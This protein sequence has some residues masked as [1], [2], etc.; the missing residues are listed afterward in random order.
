MA[1]IIHPVGKILQPAGDGSGKQIEQRNHHQ[2]AR[3]TDRDARADNGAAVAVDVIQ[4]NQ[5]AERPAVDAN[6]RAADIGKR[7][8]I[9]FALIRNVIFCFLL[10]RPGGGNRQKLAVCRNVGKNR[11]S[12]V[13]DQ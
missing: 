2:K 12:A 10:L 6:L 3:R 1:D 5:I 8:K 7:G 4:R 13:I 9:L 11:P